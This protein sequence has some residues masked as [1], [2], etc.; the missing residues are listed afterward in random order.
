[1]SAAAGIVAPMRRR[2]L[3]AGLAAL[4]ASAALAQTPNQ[5][6]TTSPL[7]IETAGGARH[8]FTVEFADDDAKRAL[9]LMFR[10]RMAPDA[11]MLFD[12][13]ADQPVAMWMRNTRIPL[14]MLFV[15]RD[16]R[17]VNIRERAVPMSEET[18]SSDGPVRAVLELNG[19][20]VSRLGI[21]PGDRLRHAMFGN[22][23]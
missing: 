7:T 13:K 4:A 22:A 23:G 11:G 1:M 8:G 3:L 9:G 14:D 18:I 2:W 6:F 12:F 15:A 17:V 20:T 16:G 19:G 10:E 5:R 21:R